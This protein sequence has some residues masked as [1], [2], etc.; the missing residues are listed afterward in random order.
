[1]ERHSNQGRCCSRMNHVRNI[2][3][4]FDSFHVVGVAIDIDVDAA[5]CCCQSTICSN[6]INDVNLIANY[7]LATAIAYD[8]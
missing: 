2:S 1:M 3:Y 8:Q 5:S 4:I 7:L 6:R